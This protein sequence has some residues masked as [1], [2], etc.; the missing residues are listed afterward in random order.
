M[1]LDDAT[2]EELAAFALKKDVAHL[3]DELHDAIEDGL[4][5]DILHVSEDVWAAALAAGGEAR[6]LCIDC[7]E[8][9]IGRSLA[10]EDFPPI[11]INEPSWTTTPRLKALFA[12]G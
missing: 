10:P 11:G 12:A 6:Y 1:R 9:R 2:P 5:A 3:C 8:A 4:D 7:L